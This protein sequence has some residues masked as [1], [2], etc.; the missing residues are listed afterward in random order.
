VETVTAVSEI[1]KPA[2]CS[3]KGETT[4]TATFT[5]ELFVTQVETVMDV[6]IDPNAH[7]WSEVSYTWSDDKSTCTATRTCGYNHDHDETETVNSASVV[8]I[9]PTCTEDGL[10]TFTATFGNPAFVEQTDTKVLE[11]LDHDWGEIVY[12]WSDDYKTCTATRPCM[13]DHSHDVVETVNATA[14]ITKPATCIAMGDTTYTATFTND[15]FKKQVET[16]TDVAIDPDA[17]DWGEITYSWSDDYRT[18][19]ATRPCMRNHEHDIVETV[20]AA[21]E[22]TKPATCSAMG[23]TTYTATFTNDLFKQQVETVTDVAINPDAHDWS[24]VS[25]TWSDDK[26]TCTATRTCGY[27]HDHDQTEKVDSTFVITTEPT[28]TDEGLKTFTATFENPAFKEQTDTAAIPATGHDWEFVGFSWSEET[29]AGFTSATAHYKCRNNENHTTTVDADLTLVVTDPTCEEKGYTTFKAVVSGDKSPD[30]AVHGDSRKSCYTDLLGHDWEFKGF[31]W[32]GNETDGYT[33]IANYECKNDPNHTETVEATVSSVVTAPTCET[34]GYT[35]YTASV[36]AVTS[37]D[38][39]DHSEQKTGNP[40]GAL[41]HD[42]EFK[43]FRWT[44]NETDGYTA[45]VADYECKNDGSHKET[46]AAVVSEQVTV[47]TCETAG[48]TTYTATVDKDASLDGEEKTEPK[49]G[50]P[51]DALGHDW[52]FKG[53]TWDGNDEDG[54]KGAIANYVCKR[55]PD[56]KE[57]VVAQ[58]VEDLTHATCEKEGKVVYS[59]KVEAGSSLDLAEQT[60]SKEITL[61]ATGHD[62]KFTGFTWT[63]NETDGYT[64]AVA[65]YV[66][67]NDSEH[68]KSVDATITENEIKAT[69]EEGG[70]TVYTATVAADVSLDGTEQTASKDAKLAAPLGHSWAEPVT[71]DWA[72]DLSTVTA[73]RICR[74]NMKHIESETVK[75]TSKVTKA[76]TEKET[77]IR[78]YTSDAFKNPA[79]KV[80]TKNIDIPKLEPKPTVKP[81]VEPT[82]A[83][84]VSLTLDKTKVTEPCGKTVTLKATLKGSSEK[85]TWKTS[86]KS[87]A[88]VDSTGK[89]TLKMAGSVTI[90]A[91]A[92][93]KSATCKFQVLYKDVTNSKDFWYTPTYYLTDKGVVKGYD[94]QT[95]FKPAN[96]CTRAQMVT[97]IWR[98]MGEPKPKTTASKFSDVKK[99]DYFYKACLWGN[100]NHIVE[101]YKDGT[102]GPQIICARRHAVT[103]LWRLAGKPNP[104][105][106]TKNKFKDLKKDA[107]YYKAALWASEKKILEGYDDGTFRPDGDCLRRQMVTFLYK[108]DKYINK[109][110]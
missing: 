41:G 3:A 14:E 99:T 6:E 88:T 79:F 69:C 20:N 38:K 19:T 1:T 93:G 32:T 33:A 86:D 39:D 26:S 82:K 62:W 76:A 48:Y 63:G 36:D 34:A 12:D 58:F 109:S 13:R 96:N 60:D 23:D 25:Y 94:K 45:A 66:C 50:K 15:L 24:E 108:Y 9:E 42:W 16:V 98:L 87:V 43:G 46:V 61:P 51:T 106:G 91:S 8:T 85:I 59:V 103:F 30:G 107:Y 11:A 73:T 83:P 53:F 27:N 4:Y 72:D 18:C 68:T 74:R 84:A 22:I 28:C 77:G 35:T 57:T 100:E 7:D 47:P 44:G 97:F 90:T 80:Q 89:V 101:G 67:Q 70:K 54:Y 37:L 52:E 75:T 102:F 78:T 81:T 110:K 92:A 71:Y 40:V 55:N 31:T 29:Q 10:E 21:A 65:N 104:S 49:T 56:H 105:S 95:L 17:H 2:T 64:A 5:N